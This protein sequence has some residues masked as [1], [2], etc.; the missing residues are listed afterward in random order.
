MFLDVYVKW[1][2]LFIVES[3]L[4]LVIFF[5]RK[6]LIVFILWFVVCLIFLMCMVFLILNLVIILFSSVFDV[7]VKV[8]IF[9]ICGL[10]DSI[11]N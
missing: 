7:F 11:C 10:V 3:L 8:G 1:I 4:L 5:L 2:N 6:Y 9:L